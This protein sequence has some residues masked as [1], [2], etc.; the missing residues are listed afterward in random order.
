LLEGLTIM[1]EC[2]NMTI[3]YYS[4]SLY[5]YIFLLSFSPS[6]PLPLF[7]GISLLLVIPC[8]SYSI[9]FLYLRCY[10]VEP[11][12]VVTPDTNWEWV[13]YISSLFSLLLILFY[14]SYFTIGQNYEYQLLPQIPTEITLQYFSTNTFVIYIDRVATVFSGVT[15]ALH[16]F[17]V[18]VFNNPPTFFRKIISQGLGHSCRK[19]VNTVNRVDLPWITWCDD[20]RWIHRHGFVKKQTSKL[21]PI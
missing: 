16:W 8:D 11:L 18:N 19:Q 21:Y 9:R 5:I 14:H 10:H 17:I 6:F 3:R 13:S 1:G 15:L 7:L 2:W 12:S 20:K 4:L